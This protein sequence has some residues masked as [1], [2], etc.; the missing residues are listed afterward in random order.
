MMQWVDRTVRRWSAG[1]GWIVALALCQPAPAAELIVDLDARDIRRG[2]VV[3]PNR[4]GRGDFTCLGR[5]GLEV[6]DN[7]TAVVFDGERDA[8]RGPIAPPELVGA[9]PRTIEAWVYNLAPDQPEKTIV[10]MGRRGGPDGTNLA[11]NCG[12]QPGWGAAAH[13]GSEQDVSWC[14]MT[15]AIGCWHHVAYTYDGTACR[16][17]RDGLE[18]TVRAVELQ[19]HPGQ[20][21]LLGAQNG[22]DGR[23]VFGNGWTGR[24]AL[25]AVRIYQGALTARRFTRECASG[26]ASLGVARLGAQPYPTL[27]LDPGGHTNEVTAVSYS[28]DGLHVVTTAA[29]LTVRVWD[30]ATGACERVF[31]VPAVY[32][33][34]KLWGLSLF[35]DGRTAVVAGNMGARLYDWTT[36]KLLRNLWDAPNWPVSL[37]LSPDEQ[38]VAVGR[39]GGGRTYL[40]ET[41]SGRAKGAWNMAGWELAFSPDGQLLAGCEADHLALGPV[42]GGQPLRYPGF[43]RGWSVAWSPDGQML[44]CVDRDHLTV[45]LPASGQQVFTQALQ[46][47]TRSVRFSPTGAIWPPAAPACT[48][49]PV[50][51]GRRCSKR[52][53]WVETFSLAWSP[54]SDQ[55]VGGAGTARSASWMC[56]RAP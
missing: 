50:P 52:R 47:E 20:P 34:R 39:F 4:T 8:C 31:Q 46:G 42:A 53:R 55:I 40:F 56:R 2:S 18:I 15:P 1:L 16:L 21:I 11:F 28:P 12:T 19:T 7:V 5:P 45:M 41:A 14:G 23:P 10:A 32:D 3:W 48:C 25:A 6:I 37:A 43:N 13:W 44:A 30:L 49:M 24:L 51:D 17:Y 33:N 38:T 26:M 29:D 22:D 54:T 36:G 27:F 35:R 9:G